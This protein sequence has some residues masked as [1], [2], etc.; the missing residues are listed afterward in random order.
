M[1]WF[2]VQFR[3]CEKT[4]KAT[5]SWIKVDQGD[6]IFASISMLHVKTEISPNTHSFPWGTGCPSGTYLSKPFHGKR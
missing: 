3:L 4:N 6:R 1:L 5:I 2:A